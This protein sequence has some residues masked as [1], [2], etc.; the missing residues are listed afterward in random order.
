VGTLLTGCGSVR[1]ADPPLTRNL[2]LETLQEV[3]RW[4]NANLR[5][6]VALVGEFITSR[7]DHEGYTYFQERAKAPYQAI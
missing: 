3:V 4:P 5:T 6:V 7:R 1:S 2:E